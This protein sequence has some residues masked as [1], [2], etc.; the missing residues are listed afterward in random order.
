MPK[1]LAVTTLFAFALAAFTGQALAATDYSG[2]WKLNVAKS[3]FGPAPAPEMMTRTITHKD[4]NLQIKTHQK[5]AQGEITSEV[6]YTTDGKE[7]TNTVNGAPSK[8]KAMYEGGKLVIESNR[9]FQGGE[10]KFKET[11]NLSGDGKVLTINNH[12][13]F[14]GNEF[15]LTY[16][17]EKQ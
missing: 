7:T 2:E 12:V 1:K 4:P 14:Q 6:K 5:G 8:G 17:F 3:E 16:V 15:D 11:Y 10:I 9:E 13:N